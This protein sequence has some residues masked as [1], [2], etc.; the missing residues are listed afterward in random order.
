MNWREASE[1]TRAFFLFKPRASLTTG[2]LVALAGIVEALSLV[3]IIPL[4]QIA[5]GTSSSSGRLA[6][7]LSRLTINDRTGQILAVLVIFAALMLLRAALISIRQSAV[8]RLELEFLSS[9]QIRLVDRLGAAPWSSVVGLRHARVN[10]ILGSDVQRLSQAAIGLVQSA[11]AVI[12]LTVQLAIAVVLSPLLTLLAILLVAAGAVLTA[13]LFRAARYVGDMVSDANLMMLNEVGQFLGALKLAVSQN[14]AGR[15]VDEYSAA[16]QG[17]V[18][19]ELAFVARENGSRLRMTIAGI[20]VAGGIAFVGLALVAV[21]VP[22]LVALLLILSRMAGPTQSLQTQALELVRSLPAYAQMRQLEAEL[23]SDGR[24]V[25]DAP[26]P[27]L[28]SVTFERV[29]YRHRRRPGDTGSGVDALDLTMARGEF[30]GI[31][32]RSGAGKTTFADLLVGLYQ[33]QSGRILLN[34]A[35]IS[36]PTQSAWRD[37]L[38]YVAQDPF[39]RHAS[40]R[41]NLLWSHPAADDAAIAQ[42]LWVADAQGL[43]ERLPEGLETVLGERGSLISGGERQR[44]ALARAVLRKPQLLILDEAT[45]AIDIDG[46]QVILRRLRETC[47]HTTILMIAHRLESL[48][49]CD[50]IL[51]FDN[52]H[53]AAEGP[54]SSMRPRLVAV[55]QEEAAPLSHHTTQEREPS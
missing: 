37:R 34:D 18:D 12:T 14:L 53:V 35:A 43:L 41:D 10:R 3:L 24:T 25:T 15:F 47:P 32:G 22:T 8:M 28:V 20:L 44:L 45:N 13:P 48:R 49:A 1:F 9:L 21:P 11:V 42:A 55:E 33:P 2:I 51:L 54:F 17:A 39:V 4:L 38:A 36:L 19:A 26:L 27:A 46:E 40:I 31:A 30:L 7:L 6:T 52:G 5:G 50:R 16:L 29:G 23:V